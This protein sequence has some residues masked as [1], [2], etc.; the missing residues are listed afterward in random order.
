MA[1]DPLPH[2]RPAHCWPFH[3]EGAVGDGVG[4]V[5]ARGSECPTAP[6][7]GTQGRGRG[8]RGPGIYTRE[9]RIPPPEVCASW[10][11]LQSVVR[12]RRETDVQRTQVQG[13]NRPCDGR[14]VCP[15]RHVLVPNPLHTTS[16]QQQRVPPQLVCDLGGGG[17]GDVTQDRK[18]RHCSATLWV[19]HTSWS[20]HSSPTPCVPVVPLTV[21]GGGHVLVHS[22]A[23]GREGSMPHSLGNGVP[24]GSPNDGL[25]WG[26][27]SPKPWG[28]FGRGT[29]GF[30][31]SQFDALH[32]SPEVY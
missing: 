19:R 15:P 21:R 22:Q 18:Q 27:P 6:S 14:A 10:S 7:M 29:C 8:G 24:S 5:R 20:T 26:R 17:G 23:C 12:T 11:L 4:S 2:H 3:L 31:K 28:P 1:E 30:A 9:T 32:N 16:A 25:P 13:P